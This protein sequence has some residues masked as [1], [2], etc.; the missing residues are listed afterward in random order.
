MF[1]LSLASGAGRDS[2][3]TNLMS[4][5][6]WLPARRVLGSLELIWSQPRQAWLAFTGVR[7]DNETIAAWKEFAEEA[8]ARGM[9][10]K[11]PTAIYWYG[12]GLSR[13]QSV[14]A[15]LPRRWADGSR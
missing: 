11:S 12:F 10:R 3:R 13:V 5:P 15:A 6:A 14:R 1:A 2:V 4:E 7:P 9:P 8:D